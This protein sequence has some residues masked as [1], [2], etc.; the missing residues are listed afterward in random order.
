MRLKAAGTATAIGSFPHDD[1]AALC[2]LILQKLPAIPCW[3]QLPK[4]AFKEQM[5]VQAS[6]GLPCVVID[7]E[8]EKI[9]FD[10]S[11]DIYPELEKCLTHVISEDVDYFAISEGYAAGLHEMVRLLENKK[12]D[13]ITWVKGQTV[14]PV[15]L[16]LTVTDQAKRSII[17]NDELFEAITKCCVMKARWQIRKLKSVH[18]HVIIFIDEPYLS[19]FGSAYINIQRDQ[20]IGLLTEI[21]EAV[22]DE[23][24]LAGVHCC[25]NTDWSLLMDTPIDIINFDAY[26]YF[27]GITLYP[28]KLGDFLEKGGVLAWGIVPTSDA[29]ATC[30]HDGLLEEIK[31]KM[32]ALEK[33]GVEKELLLS[34]CLITPSCGTGTLSVD[35]ADRVLNVTARLSESFRSEQTP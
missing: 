22:H 24:A 29:I 7:E 31:K 17:Y 11:G 14:G 26:G 12:P 2:G 30:S 27:E 10:T 4:R 8:K 16:G 35:L 1:A 23:G 5:Y 34:N 25:G 32:A 15:S 9:Y 6:E 33:K 28:E 3:P 21:I 19:S 20:V 13:T 18:P